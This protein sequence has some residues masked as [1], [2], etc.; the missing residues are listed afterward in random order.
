MRVPGSVLLL[1]LG[2]VRVS[3]AQVEAE[4]VVTPPPGTMNTP[5]APAPEAAPPV[6]GYD[7]PSLYTQA[8][9]EPSEL[10]V[11]VTPNRYG[12][13]GALELGASAGLVVASGFRAVSVAPTFGAFIS[14]HLRISGIAS[15]A[16]F[17][18]G[19]SST[20][21][22]SAL[23]E[24]GYH[25]PLGPAAFWFIA[26]GAGVTYATDMSAGL[27]VAPRI[28][29]NV[30]VGTHGVLTPS[31][32]YEYTTLDAPTDAAVSDVTKAAVGSIV[33]ANLGY[34]ITW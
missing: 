25:N 15:V 5:V 3:Q 32:A 9:T 26:G 13:A 29:I 8:P 18:A 17:K 33:R 31:L 21:L 16:S 6:A 14:D 7:D 2:A 4:P 1:L 23:G 28:G 19:A 10:D 24:V 34:A 30:L 20:T 27:I 11:M 22:W 12:R